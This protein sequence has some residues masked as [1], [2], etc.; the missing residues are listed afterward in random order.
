MAAPGTVVTVTASPAPFTNPSPTGAW[1][2]D[3]LSERGPVGV[4][5]LL[6]SLADYTALLGNRVAY[7]TLFDSADVFFREG[8]NAMYVSRCVGPAAVA[9]TVSL[10]D[11]AA[12]PVPTLSVT[13]VGPG[14]A[15]NNLSVGVINAPGSTTTFLLQISLSGVLVET[16]SVCSAPADAVAWSKTSRYVRVTDLAS[17]SAAPT[18]NPAVNAGAALISGTDDNANVTDTVR[19]AARAVFTADLG[20]G[21]V[22][23][24]GVTSA[25]TQTAL[26]NHAVGFNR[27]AV[28]DAVDTATAATLITAATTLQSAAVDPSYYAIVG[29]WV[30]YPGVPTGTATPAYPRTVPPSALTAGLMARNDGSYEANRAAAG[31]NGLSAGALAVTRVYTPADLDALNTA[32]INIIRNIPLQGGIQ[33]YGYRSGS[34]LPAWVDLANVRFR[35]Q[36]VFEGQQIGA[37]FV[38]A[39]IDGRGQTLS[40]FNG[41]LA[42]SLTAHWAAGSLYGATPQDAYKVN[43]GPTVNTPTTIAARQLNAVES[44]RMS[45][46][47]E[48]VNIQIVKYAVTQTLP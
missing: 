26:A 42:A 37:Q 27:V 2:V 19:T 30:T 35:M 7:G 40:A 6:T 34:I 15:G 12:T 18:N 8:G 41:A 36:L 46:S 17:A 14:V 23:S 45:P 10:S 32:G 13:A 47:A 33:L 3:G 39:Q 24:P 22:S 21:Q 28:L 4:P 9:A 31:Q 16:S 11:R 43:T 5:V 1:F 29:P 25:V 48:L 20:P 44:V 38:F